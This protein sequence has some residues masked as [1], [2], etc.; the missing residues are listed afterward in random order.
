TDKDVY[1]HHKPFAFQGLTREPISQLKLCYKILDKEV[2]YL[3]Q[4]I[5]KPLKGRLM[6][7]KREFC[8]SVQKT[9]NPD[10]YFLGFKK[11]LENK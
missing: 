10:K 11:E 5:N 2:S 7:T 1:G 8:S 9:L 4:S 3:D 6:N